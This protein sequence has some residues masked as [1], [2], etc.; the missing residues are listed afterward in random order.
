M[1]TKQEIIEQLELLRQYLEED[2]D[3]GV[4]YTQEAIDYLSSQLE[5]IVIR[6][7]VEYWC[8]ECGTIC[9][10]YEQGLSCRCDNRWETEVLDAEDYPKKWKKVKVNICSV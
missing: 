1:K 4:G 3:M 2:G 5:P 10:I 9:A 7:N 8:E 6:T